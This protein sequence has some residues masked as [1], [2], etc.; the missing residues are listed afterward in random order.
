VVRQQSSLGC[1]VLAGQRF[2]HRRHHGS[3]DQLCFFGAVA[4][5]RS[6]RRLRQR[7]GNLSAH[8]RVS[9]Q[10][11]AATADANCTSAYTATVAAAN[12]VAIVVSNARTISK[13]VAAAHAGDNEFT[14]SGSRD[15]GAFSKADS[16][17]DASTD[18][19]AR[20]AGT[21][22]KADSRA[23]TSTDAL[24]DSPCWRAMPFVCSVCAVRQLGHDD[25]SMPILRFHVPANGIAVRCDTQHRIWQRVSDTCTDACTESGADA[26]AVA[27][28]ESSAVAAAIT[29]ADAGAEPPTVSSAV[30]SAHARSRIAVLLF[31][32]VRSVYRRVAASDAPQ[33]SVLRLAMPGGR[34]LQPQPGRSSG[35]HL[36]NARTY[37]VAESAVHIGADA[38]ATD[39][40]LNDSHVFAAVFPNELG[41]LRLL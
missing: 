3:A 19:R 29:I 6:L 21:F 10:C 7:T 36:S 13:T 17:T 34:R 26:A 39:I 25:E 23:N 41:N 9:L 12:A 1:G 14:N 2:H 30:A 27:R 28:P 40:V 11:S 5:V 8:H 22:S 18:A 16:R 31:C 33:L 4:F 37:A 35:W 38:S 32:D 24:A 15:A 20:Y